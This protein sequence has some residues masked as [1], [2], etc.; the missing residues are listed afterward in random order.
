MAKTSKPVL[1]P[2]EGSGDPTKSTVKVTYTVT[3]DDTDLALNQPYRVLVRVW[4]DDTNVAGD[5]SGGTDDQ[6]YWIYTHN[7]IVPKTGA[8]QTFTD[9]FQPSDVWL[10]EDSS[11]E[12]QHSTQDDLRVRITLIPKKPEEFTS[13]E[14]NLQQVTLLP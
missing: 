2:I 13:D 1:H 7:H 10:N 9:S 8:T 4:G 14:S 6:R 3:F 11:S 5:G 12:P